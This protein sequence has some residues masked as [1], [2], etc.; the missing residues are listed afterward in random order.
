MIEH[1]TGIFGED[2][3]KVFGDPPIRK[4]GRRHD[5][6]G[7]SDSMNSGHDP[8]N[9][10]R[11]DSSLESIERELYENDLSPSPRSIHWPGQLL[12]P[13][14]LSRDSGLTSSNNDLYP[15]SEAS[16]TTDSGVESKK[17]T[18]G[19]NSS[20]GSQTGLRHSRSAGYVRDGMD[21]GF[22]EGRSSSP[23]ALRGRRVSEPTEVAYKGKRI[24]VR[25]TRSAG[26]ALE[27]SPDTSDNEVEISPETLK[28]LQD[29]NQESSLFRE[30]L[31]AEHLERRQQSPRGLQQNVHGHSHARVSPRDN[32][33]SVRPKTTNSPRAPKWH[34][35]SSSSSSEGLFPSQAM[36][37]NSKTA[38]HQGVHR[39]LSNGKLQ[40]GTLVTDR[41]KTLAI[42][43]TN[44]AQ[45][46]RMNSNPPREFFPRDATQTSLQNPPQQGVLKSQ[47]DPHIHERR[48]RQ[49][50]AE[51]ERIMQQL[52]P[53][54]DSQQ[55]HTPPSY[56]EAMNRRAMFHRNVSV[57]SVGLKINP[58]KTQWN[59]RSRQPTRTKG[60]EGKQP[61]SSRPQLRATMSHDD[62][63]FFPHDD[64]HLV[65]SGIIYL[66]S[67]SES[68]DEETVDMES[69]K[70]H[71]S[72]P[73]HALKV[74]SV[75]R[76][77]SD[78]TE[79]R[80][81]RVAS[82]RH[83]QDSLQRS[84]SERRS[85]LDSPPS[86]EPTSIFFA[87]NT[88]LKSSS[89]VNGDSKSPRPQPT[90]RITSPS[91]DRRHLGLTSSNKP[92][93]RRSVSVE[94]KPD[95]KQVGR[96]VSN[97][98]TASTD[99]GLSPRTALHFPFPDPHAEPPKSPSSQPKS[100]VREHDG[101]GDRVSELRSDEEFKQ[102]ILQARRN[103]QKHRQPGSTDSGTCV[104]EDL[105]S[106]EFT[107]ESYV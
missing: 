18:S 26:V 21:I 16:D 94:E 91:V 87:Q 7:D 76:T 39:Q 77:S 84:S 69:L 74:P 43:P 105:D 58:N 55:R 54:P 5:S 15:E 37:Q 101:K 92:S 14:T 100:T 3:V 66:S 10:K 96:S 67:D 6:S 60:V 89:P 50:D 19:S 29:L 23:S 38:Q 40:R 62:R 83:S 27:N 33:E 48:R 68:S 44:V 13:S 41:P 81:N 12:S 11:D 90:R 72:H 70:L 31:P 36:P 53:I 73:V 51:R 82:L 85:P 102:K 34:S 61:R 1:T 45:P 22:H 24:V 49:R 56:Q 79:S 52:S 99:S 17:E 104:E 2:V 98:S 80:D 63:T 9:L 25:P 103:W 47:S 93:I 78:R 86:K 71:K 107:E 32:T 8:S 95:H 28:M 59:S 57:D 4:E 64:S 65:E 88:T 42:R 106:I 30:I 97:N 75:R 35:P 20:M 46:K